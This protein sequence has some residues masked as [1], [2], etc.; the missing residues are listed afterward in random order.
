VVE[1]SHR[2]NSWTVHPLLSEF[3]RVDGVTIENP[4]PS[5]NTEW[6]N[7]ESGPNAAKFELPD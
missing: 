6:M 7:P 5:P 3:V 2:I 4:A 1:G